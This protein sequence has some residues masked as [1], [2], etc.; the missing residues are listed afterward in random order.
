MLSRVRQVT[1]EKIKALRVWGGDCTV[2]LSSVITPLRVVKKRTEV[3]GAASREAL[4]EGS[5][6]GLVHPL[7]RRTIGAVA[8]G[9]APVGRGA[10][11]AQVQ[12]LHDGDPGL[13]LD[14]R[15]E[16]FAQLPRGVEA[17]P[18]RRVCGH[19]TLEAL[20]PLG[21]PD[22]DGGRGARRAGHSRSFT[23]RLSKPGMTAYRVA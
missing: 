19:V 8:R 13:D 14:G 3:R 10:V 2:C 1:T 16:G 7:V 9:D 5:G 6:V 18:L 20:E 21:G 4:Y 12:V 15:E 22:L 17:I 11:E 23:G